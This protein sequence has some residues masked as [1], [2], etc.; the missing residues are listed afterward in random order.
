VVGGRTV[1]GRERRI[2]Q[3]AEAHVDEYL[4]PRHDLYWSRPR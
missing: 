2:M 1:P 3:D 4:A